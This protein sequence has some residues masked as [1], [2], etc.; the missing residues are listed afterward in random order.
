MPAQPAPAPAEL[1]DPMVALG[2]SIGVTVGGVAILAASDG[3]DGA[4]L[5]GIGAL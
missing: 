1:R 4:V 5:L 3:S 2:L